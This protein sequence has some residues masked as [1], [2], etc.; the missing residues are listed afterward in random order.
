VSEGLLITDMPG[1]PEFIDRCVKDAAD[2]A[3][4]CVG[5]PEDDTR[6]VLARIRDDFEASL[7]REFGNLTAKQIADAFVATVN[8]CRNEI[9]KAAQGSGTGAIQ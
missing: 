6:A 3:F 2:L 5:K 7:S 9:E 1:G 8:R 4:F